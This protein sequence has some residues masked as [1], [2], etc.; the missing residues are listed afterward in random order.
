MSC[1]SPGCIFSR[2]RSRSP[3]SSSDCR[4]GSPYWFVTFNLISCS[5]DPR[6]SLW[7]RTGPR[8]RRPYFSI[9]ADKA[10]P[11]WLHHHC[12]AAWSQSTGPLCPPPPI[13]PPPRKRSTWN[14]AVLSPLVPVSS[15]CYR[16]DSS[17]PC[18]R[19]RSV[20]VTL[21]KRHTWPRCEGRARPRERERCPHPRQ[22][23][24][25]NMG[26]G[27]TCQKDRSMFP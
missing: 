24:I 22:S 27:A 4:H 8:W 5:S 16:G 6:R 18:C 1:Y 2:C 23:P 12:S 9:V 20:T 11:N 7:A 14:V 13:H 25:W 17:P 3:A 19:D 10:R 21:L 26:N 15:G